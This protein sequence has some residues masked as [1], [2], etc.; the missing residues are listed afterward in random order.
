M[1]HQHR[2]EVGVRNPGRYPARYPNF[3]TW[4]AAI[5]RREGMMG[6]Q[7]EGGGVER[8]KLLLMLGIWWEVG[9]GKLFG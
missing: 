5:G 8:I 3:Q 1:K 6:A 4:S 7:V 2:R 9:G